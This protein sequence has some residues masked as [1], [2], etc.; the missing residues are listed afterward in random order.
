MSVPIEKGVYAPPYYREFKCIASAC[1][2]S[3]CIDWEIGIDETTYA[4]YKQIGE[5]LET[6]EVCEDGPCFALKEDG[7][8]PHLNDEGLCKIILNHGEAYLSEICENHPRFYHVINS[9]RTE[10]GLGIVC[11]EACRLILEDE[12]PFS[13]SKTEELDET[14]PYDEVLFDALPQ[15]DRIISI[16]EENE[17]FEAILSRLE[18]AFA[19]PMPYTS[20][21]WLD[22]FLSLE[23]L[24]AAWEKVLQ[25]MRGK[26][27]RTNQKNMGYDRYYKRLLIYFVYRHVSI[28]DG[29]ENLRARLAF[30]MLSVRVIRS[31][32]EEASTQTKEMLIDHARRY[33]AEIEY[34]EDN[35]EELIFSFERI[36]LA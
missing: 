6:V 9:G 33:S 18:T 19:I 17:R 22:R 24:D 32:F 16:I 2:H 36:L 27:L 28:A 23:I 13:L 26:F 20:D 30:A 31:L 29:E 4:K 10:A 34:S 25:A 21:E 35:T 5:I 8:C 7:R 12:A 15:R 3:C 1:R 11:E 14:E